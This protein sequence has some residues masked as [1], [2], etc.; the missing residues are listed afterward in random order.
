MPSPREPQSRRDTFSLGRARST[1]SF[2]AYPI[3]AN[4]GTPE[5]SAAPLR[6]EELAEAIREAETLFAAMRPRIGALARALDALNGLSPDLFEDVSEGEQAFTLR[7]ADALRDSPDATRK[8]RIATQ[9]F[10]MADTELGNAK[11]AHAQLTAGAAGETPESGAPEFSITKFRGMLHPIY[12]LSLTFHGYPLLQ[13]LFPR[14]RSQVT[15]RPLSSESPPAQAG[16]PET[17]PRSESASLMQQAIGW[18]R[19]LVN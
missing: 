2:D 7:L 19:G 11:A 3:A 17:A 9:Q 6:T 5:A 15:T 16:S 18:F 14:A 4:G 13:S 12:N 10:D 1:G 8:A